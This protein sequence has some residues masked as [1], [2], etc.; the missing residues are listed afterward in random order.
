MMLHR[1][2]DLLWGMSFSR[3]LPQ[4][5]QSADVQQADQATPIFSGI[6][7]DAVESGY[8]SEGQFCFRQNSM[9]PGTIQSITQILEE[10]DR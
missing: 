5:F 1:V 6:Q 8:D 2:G 4:S 7:S 9:L 3:L 10:Q